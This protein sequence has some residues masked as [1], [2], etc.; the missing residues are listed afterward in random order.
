M[1]DLGTTATVPEIKRAYRRLAQQLHPDKQ[2]GSEEARRRF[3]EVARAYRTLM[4]IARATEEGQRLGICRSCRDFGEVDTG[5]DGGLYCP[6]CIVQPYRRRFLPLPPL[7]VVRCVGSIVLLTAAVICLI[8]AW[9]TGKPIYAA[10]S[11]ITGLAS[12]AALAHTCLTVV[13]CLKPNE[14]KTHG[15]QHRQRR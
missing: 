5:A 15:R 2:S 8:A 4:A 7:V 10:A 14:R 12:L 6:R 11:F 3:I 13:H 1:L 9:S